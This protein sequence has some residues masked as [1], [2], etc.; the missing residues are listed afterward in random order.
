MRSKQSFVPRG[1]KPG[2]LLLGVAMLV[3]LVRFFRLVDRVRALHHWLQTFGHWAPVIFIFLFVLG[4][5]LTLPGSVMTLMAGVFFDTPL[6]IL[7]ATLGGTLGNA[8]TFLI[9]RNFAREDLARWASQ[10]ERF[11]KLDRMTEKHGAWI[12]ALLRLMPLSPFSVLNYAFG[13]TRVRLGEY[14]FW[15]CL[16]TLPSTFFYILSARTV[17]HGM[18]EHR[19]PWALIAL[20]AALTL[21]LAFL[22]AWAQRRLEIRK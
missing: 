17:L 11:R 4:T 5:V 9:A 16:C 2:L 20:L 10:N 8:A 13:L 19:M 3:V 22:M 18:R 7:T 1:W 12:V 21:V 14:L 15:S 6:A